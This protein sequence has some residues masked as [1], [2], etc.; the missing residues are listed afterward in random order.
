MTKAAIGVFGGSFDPVHY[1]HL[2]TAWEL[3]QLLKLQEMLFLP[4]GTTPLKAPNRATAEQRLAMLQA[5]TR[6][7]PQFRVDARELTRDGPS[8]TVDTL[9]EL[10]GELPDTPICLIVGM[11]AWLSFPQWHR[12]Q[13]ILDLTHIVVAHRPGCELETTGLI[14]E[15]MQERQTN[16][17]ADLHAALAGQIFVHEVTQLEI[18]S[19][20]IRQLYTGGLGVDFLLPA[21]VRELIKESGCYDAD[22]D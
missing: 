9:I 1:G 8:Y 18:S 13:D 11:D 22:S 17:A 3:L 16:A 10:R 14:A 19:S 7:Y 4:C 15:L 20:A 12:W 6:D 21:G 2:R 5:D